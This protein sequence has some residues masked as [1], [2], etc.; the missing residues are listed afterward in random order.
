MAAAR[1][2]GTEDQFSM[3][4]DWSFNED[5][6]EPG[7]TAV[8]IPSSTP[9][10]TRHS[11]P[12]LTPNS[13]AAWATAAYLYL[14][15]ISFDG[16]WLPGGHGNP[17]LFRWLLDWIKVKLG[18]RYESTTRD[19]TGELWLWRVVIG[20]YALTVAG[21]KSAAEVADETDDD[22]A[23]DEQ[24]QREMVNLANWYS[25]QLAKP[26]QATWAPEWEN[27]KE[28]LEKVQWLQIPGSHGELVLNTLWQD[29]LRDSSGHE[30]NSGHTNVRGLAVPVSSNTLA[31]DI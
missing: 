13:S 20:A 9:S 1:N 17:S 11:T 14:N 7:T 4:F 2:A 8:M 5:N 29:S 6:I 15:L 12:E 28:V 22:I 31:I 10:N 21:S 30:T 25:E 24:G 3:G 16:G 19:Y 26:R 27:A 23:N 18:D